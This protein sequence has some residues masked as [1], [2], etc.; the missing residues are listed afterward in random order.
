VAKKLT[1][2]FTGAAFVVSVG[3]V[4]VMREARDMF[5]D[6]GTQIA[7]LRDA[8]PV[9]EGAPQSRK[10]SPGSP[11]VAAPRQPES[12][13][14]LNRRADKFLLRHQY[15]DLQKETGLGT[16]DVE[17]IA[18][19]RSSTEAQQELALGPAKYLLWKE[20]QARTDA[21]YAVKQFQ[22][23]ISGITDPLREDQ[24][25]MLYATIFAEKTRR[26]EELRLRTYGPP[27]DRR[28]AL[29]F[30]LEILEI[31][32]SSERRVLDR[33]KSFLDEQQLAVLPE[34]VNDSNLAT[35]RTFL[36]K[37]R[38]GANR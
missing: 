31:K 34:A 8:V 4:F 10:E 38:S 1:A 20:Y 32:Q 18:D 22:R 19:W 25:Q 15:P 33:A 28:L 2:I 23:K 6:A 24:I 14:D 17:K 37:L 13:A 21:Q 26:D 29:D 11:Q 27:I 7:Q 30:E 12:D 35:R 9:Q 5:S 16:E 36:E 3:A